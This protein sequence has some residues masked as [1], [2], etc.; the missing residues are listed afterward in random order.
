MRQAYAHRA[1]LVLESG[2]DERAPGGAI[3][4]ALCG[5][6]AHEPPCPLAAHHTAVE[7]H[8]DELRLRILFAA[9]PDRVDEIRRRIDTALAAGRFIGPDGVL[10]RWQAV[11]SGCDRLAPQE[12]PHA[13]R[14]LR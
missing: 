7:R 8:D 14:L 3:T 5:D 9:A 13:R 10:S 12:R 4:A 1:V 2:A 11:E 6:A